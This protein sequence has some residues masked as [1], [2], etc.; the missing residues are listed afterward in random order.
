MAT[1]TVTKIEFTRGGAGN[2]WTTIN[3]VEYATW[4]NISTID[5][6]KGDKVTF[7]TYDAPLWH[8]QPKVKCAQNIKKAAP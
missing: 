2:Q 4:W 7:D 5:W 8:G 1:G 3:G 6:S